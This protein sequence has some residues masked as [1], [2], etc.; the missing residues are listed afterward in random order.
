MFATPETKVIDETAVLQ[1]CIAL[2]CSAAVLQDAL[3]AVQGN[4]G[5]PAE[6]SVET[7]MGYDANHLRDTAT[8]I[9]ITRNITPLVGNADGLTSGDL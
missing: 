9:Q 8:G 5:D 4:S 3:T 2:P 7:V 1:V 6:I